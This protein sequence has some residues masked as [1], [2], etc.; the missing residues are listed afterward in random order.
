MAYTNQTLITNYLQRTLTA[1]EIA[2]LVILIPAIKQWIDRKTSST[3]DSAVATT[4]YFDVEGRGRSIDIDPCTD[5]TAV[6][7]YD[8]DGNLEQTYTTLT[9]Y[10]AEPVNETVKRELVKRN[11]TW[12]TGYR[13]IAVTAKFSEYGESGA[14]PDDIQTVATILA[15]ET[16]NQGKIASS[17]GNVSSES[18]E[19]HSI[20]YDTSGSSI[21]AIVDANPVVKSIL[22][23]RK[24]I[25]VG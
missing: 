25:F 23:G 16:L 4:R 11:S 9:D 8:V 20:N 13:R 6:G 7:L 19:G 24:D 17:G 12:A 18:L 15:A 2:F 1:N 14:V 3:F 10:V 5:I 22:D 21:D